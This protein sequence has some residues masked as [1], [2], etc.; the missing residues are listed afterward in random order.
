MKG[1]LLSS[2]RQEINHS[3]IVPQ[4]ECTFFYEPQIP[5][6]LTMDREREKKRERESGSI[7]FN[8]YA[9]HIFD[10]ACSHNTAISN[11]L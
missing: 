11:N 2:S 9:T 8:K 6:N 5:K 1:N 7:K 3:T 10:L 4:E